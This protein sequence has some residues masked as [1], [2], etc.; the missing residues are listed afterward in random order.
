MKAIALVLLCGC[1]SLTPQEKAQMADS[2]YAAEQMKCVDDATTLEQSKKCRADK[3][4]KWDAGSEAG[5]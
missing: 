1:T 3:A 4:A 2:T 5:K